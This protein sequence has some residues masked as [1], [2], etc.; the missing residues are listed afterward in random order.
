MQTSNAV[1]PPIVDAKH[2]GPG[3]GSALPLVGKDGADEIY[4][5]D[6]VVS[7]G[8][9]AVDGFPELTG[10]VDLAR[11]SV[12]GLEQLLNLV[13][14]HLLA[15]I[16]QDILELPDADKARHILVKHLE[17]TAVLLRLAWVAEASRAVQHALKSLK[18]DCRY[19]IQI[20]ILAPLGRIGVEKTLVA[21]VG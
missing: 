2:G 11:A 3:S 18:V 12:D 5:T 13:V 19:C 14:R 4:M 21:G 10:V 8:A 15:Q 17:S 6:N 1:S 16:R 20:S 9:D 7:K